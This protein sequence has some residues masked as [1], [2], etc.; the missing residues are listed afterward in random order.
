MLFRS[1]EHGEYIDF[2]GILYSYIFLNLMF[3]DLRVD[4]FMISNAFMGKFL[5]QYLGKIRGRIFSILGR[6]MRDALMNK[7]AHS[8]KNIKNLHNG[9]F[10]IT[11]N[12]RV[13]D[14]DV[15]KAQF[16]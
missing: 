5:S 4:E 15:F 2:I 9:I 7:H 12:F 11:G 6:M 8:W 3:K 1:S 14:F 16:H 10:V 13:S